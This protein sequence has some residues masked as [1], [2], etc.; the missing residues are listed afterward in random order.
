MRIQHR[1][2]SFEKNKRFLILLDKLSIRYK[3]VDR[4]LDE[5]T[6]LY[7]LEFFLYEDNP[8]FIEMTAE[9]TAF[10]I[11]PQIGTVYD[12]DD[13]AKAN[14]FYI[15][16]GEYQYPQPEAEFGYL[17]ATYN[18]DHYCSNCG[19]GRMQNAPFRLKTTPKQPNNQFW[20]L[21]WVHDAVFIR[22]Q[23]K[24]ILEM[25]H[26]REISFSKPVLHKKGEEVEDLWQMHIQT[27]L[28]Q[29]ID[30]YNLSKEICEYIED[31][32]SIEVGPPKLIHYCG[33]IK[34]N[35]PRRGAITF[36]QSSFQN[37]PDI[38]RSHE[39]FGSGGKAMQLVIVSKR[40]KQLVEKNKLKG[41][42]FAPIFEERF[43]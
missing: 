33:R 29:G 22:S 24:R 26:V 9:L 19:I 39:W 38:V 21:H 10:G 27:E 42:S 30:D 23:A 32:E 17:R 15:F 2:L 20:G 11:E 37:M 4:N 3:I 6:H 16:T 43:E 31:K 18:L 25:E 1:Y 35:F 14:W 34:Y 5:K 36:S 12:K 40:I 41:L 13:I 7:I 8:R 28:G